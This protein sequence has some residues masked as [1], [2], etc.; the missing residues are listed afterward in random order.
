M[1]SCDGRQNTAEWKQPSRLLAV[2][3]GNK[4][5]VRLC[6]SPSWTRLTL[7]DILESGNLGKYLQHDSVTCRLRTL[8]TA[9]DVTSGYLLV[10]MLSLLSSSPQ[11]APHTLGALKRAGNFVCGRFSAL[12]CTFS[13]HV[14]MVLRIPLYSFR[15]RY[16]VVR[17]LHC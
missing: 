15:V 7:E 17:E 2:Q 12:H 11:H 10:E 5:H 9:A 8:L 4:S 16:V 3:L 1:N 6:F 14:R 13:G